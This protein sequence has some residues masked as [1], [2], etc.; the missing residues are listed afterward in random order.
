MKQQDK[1]EWNKPI[2]TAII[3]SNPEENVLC[4]CKYPNDQNGSHYG[5]GINSRDCWNQWKTQSGD[6]KTPGKS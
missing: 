4:G 5:P 3:R 1:K 2:L 6:C